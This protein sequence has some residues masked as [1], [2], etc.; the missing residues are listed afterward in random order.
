MHKVISENERAKRQ[1]RVD[2]A[3]GNVELEGFK[4]DDETKQISEKYING[5]ITGDE[6]VELIFAR[7]RVGQKTL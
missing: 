2:F 1:Q 4:I 7:I 5:E 6:H 3:K